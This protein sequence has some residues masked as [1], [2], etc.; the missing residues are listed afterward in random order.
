LAPLVEGRP[1]RG[2]WKSQKLLRRQVHSGNHKRT[3]RVY[4]RMNPHLR[5]P[6]K[7]RRP[8]RLRVPLYVPRLPKTIWSSDFIS[9]TLLFG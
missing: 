3:Y 8:K 9:D 2:F 5:R 1:S 6:A 7:Q 4:K